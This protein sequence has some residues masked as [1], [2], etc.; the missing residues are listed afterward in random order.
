[1]KCLLDTHTFLWWITNSELLSDALVK[2]FEMVEIQFF[3]APPVDGKLL[4]K[5]V[6]VGLNSRISLRCSSQNKCPSMTSRAYQSRWVT[7]SGC[8]RFLNIIV[9]PSIECLWLSVNWRRCP[10]LHRI[11]KLQSMK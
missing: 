8:T 2:W 10:S 9:T 1:M 11:H 6:M 4:L 3:S 5:Q 7:L